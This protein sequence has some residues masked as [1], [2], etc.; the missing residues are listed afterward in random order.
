MSQPSEDCD[1]AF[2]VFVCAFTDEIENLFFS[3]LP[4]KTQK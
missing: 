2:F 4:M 3:V 1:E